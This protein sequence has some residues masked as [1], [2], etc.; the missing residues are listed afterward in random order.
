MSLK[1]RERGDRPGTYQIYG[2]AGGQLIRQTAQSHSL[3]LAKEEAA[4]LEARLIKEELTGAKGRRDRLFAEIAEAYI[5]N[6]KRHPAQITRILAIVRALGDKRVSAIDQE[7]VDRITHM[8]IKKQHPA[9]NT[10]KITVTMPLRAVINFGWRR[11][12]CEAIP[13]FELPDENRAKKTATILPHEARL[14]VDAASR[15]IRPILVTMFGIGSRITET[16]AL[17]WAD[18]DLTTAKATLIQKGRNGG[19]VRHVR[20]PPAVVAAL[21]SIPGPREG[22]VFLT[23]FGLPYRLDR[24]KEG[25]GG[26]SLDHAL[27]S[28]MRRAGFAG[29]PWTAHTLRHSWASWHL[30]VYR[31]PKRLQEDGGW[32]RLTMIDR[33]THLAPEGHEAAILAF[34]GLGAKVDTKVTPDQNGVALTA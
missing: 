18:V 23:R 6:Q 5:E 28:A 15:H 21:A 4:L 24:Q 9:R 30:A 27:T 1:V 8:L 33:Y 34:W 3:K 14:L 2:S 7:E 31:S 26:G 22:R 12:W 17:E 10:V 11:R 19:R 13:P 32:D 16:L 29:Q 25:R 20:L